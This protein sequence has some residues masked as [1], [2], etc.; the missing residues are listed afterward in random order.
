MTLHF[1]TT[2][3]HTMVKNVDGGRARM[4]KM[5][6]PEVGGDGEAGVWSGR[7]SGDGVKVAR[8]L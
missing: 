4:T 7:C 3:G 6:R 1:I 5:V 2:D 8:L